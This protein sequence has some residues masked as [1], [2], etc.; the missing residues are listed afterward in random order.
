MTA[1]VRKRSWVAMGSVPVGRRA[2]LMRALPISRVVRAAQRGLGQLLLVLQA[3][4]L[5][6]LNLKTVR[7]LLPEQECG[8]DDLRALD[9]PCCETTKVEK[10]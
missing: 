7:L 1:R 6:S 5:D 4:A 3:E 10:M 9:R 8:R 2:D